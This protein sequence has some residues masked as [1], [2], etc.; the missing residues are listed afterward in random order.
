MYGFIFNFSVLFLT[1]KLIKLFFDITLNEYVRLRVQLD[2]K[3]RN[4]T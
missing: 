3:K 2:Q 4:K 1:F